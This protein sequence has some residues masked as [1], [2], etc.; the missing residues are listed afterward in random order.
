MTSIRIYVGTYKKYNEGSLFGRWIDLNDYSDFKELKDEM[1]NL[2]KDEEDPEFMIQDFECSE[3][4]KEL[5]LINESYISDE[6]YN[7]I[8]AI[9]NCSYDEEIIESY[10]NCNGVYDSI[11]EIIEKVEEAYSG[12]FFSDIEFVQEL[13]ESTGDIPEN[14]PNYIHIDWERTARDIMFDYSTDNNHYFRNI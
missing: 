9:N 3:A 13:L 2:H 5:G 7:V 4:I 11:E 10:I 6:I 12:E 1:F 14:L 8:E